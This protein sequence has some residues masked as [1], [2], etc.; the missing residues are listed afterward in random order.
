ML[1]N[2]KRTE[3]D[4]IILNEKI[5]NL[6][7]TFCTKLFMKLT[8]NIS[9]PDLYLYILKFEYANRA[10]EDIKKVLSKL[11]N[12][13]HLNE[14]LK[15]QEDKKSNEY[16]I[17]MKE[18][19]K[20]S[21]HQ[22]KKKYSLLKKANED[23]YKFYFILNGS[24]SKLNLIFKKEKISYEKYL[25]YILKME[26][27]QE[28]HILEKCNTLNKNLI[29]IDINNLSEFFEQ[30][31]E[32]NYEQ[33]KSRAKTELINEG[34]V[35]NKRKV[36]LSS[37]DCYLNIGKFK[38]DERNEI[39]T[40][41]RFFIY[42]GQ[43]IKNKTLE[44][45]DIIGD[46]SFNEYSE[47]NAYIC[48][49]N[50]DISYINK[51]ETKKSE[52]YKYIFKKYQKI[53]KQNFSKFYIFKNFVN[54]PDDLFFEKNIY[55]YL[56]YKKYSKGEK[57]IIQNSQYEGIY[58]ILDGKINISISQNFTELSNT[59]MNLQ[60]SI[61]N[62]KDYASKI[63]KSVDILNEF[64]LKYILN[65]R[66][67]KIINLG[68]NNKINADILSSNE[69]LNN[70]KGSKNITFYDM[71]IGDILGMNELFDYKTELYNFSAT[72]VSDETHLFFLSK[73][74]FEN[75]IQQNRS[76]MNNA[77]QLIDL[78]AKHLI[79]K[80]NSFRIRYSKEVLNNIKIKRNLLT[81][82]I[83]KYSY[84]KKLKLCE[85]SKNN[86]VFISS[87]NFKKI[88]HN[89]NKERNQR[90]QRNNFN[91]FKNNTLLTY[92]KNEKLVRNNSISDMFNV[93]IPEVL[94]QRNTRFISPLSVKNSNSTN[95]IKYKTHVKHLGDE[96][97]LLKTINKNQKQF[98]DF[99]KE[100]FYNSDIANNKELLPK[101]KN[102]R[103][104]LNNNIRTKFIKAMN[105]FDF[106]RNKLKISEN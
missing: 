92:L 21:F 82:N 48:E 95:Y 31:K 23:L 88:N 52:L 27:L 62:F 33:L 70:F 77:I 100:T 105:S 17:I 24:V 43:Y 46:L 80:I 13:A 8:S 65:K 104:R 14:Y 37:L 91:L 49:K 45:G 61:F 50:C 64:Y 20:I 101:I 42:V 18:I 44:K 4:N 51:L 74:N 6:G 40:P 60:Y 3:N 63:I 22:K 75:I 67:N 90:N 87:V 54:K 7:R 19:S 47:G 5:M 69:Y 39:N 78:K 93:N 84:E 12:L 26:I 25:V 99:Q 34:F 89:Q 85:N 103:N 32:Y 38:I 71:G 30:N 58:F 9:I 56:I 29:N 94:S 16:N 68:I 96:I 10:N 79:G 98:D 106:R 86:S 76:I 53:F 57:I 35:F 102:G 73:K 55:P 59:M 11:K 15:F 2:I 41:M 83:S 36:E 28:K 81:K 72:C 66:K 97:N 1:K